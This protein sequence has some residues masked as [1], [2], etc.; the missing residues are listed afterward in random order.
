[1]RFFTK[2]LCAW[3]YCH[4]S[5]HFSLISASDSSETGWLSGHPLLDVWMASPTAVLIAVTIKSAYLSISCV[6]VSSGTSP[7]LSAASSVY[8]N[9]SQS[10]WSNSYLMGLVCMFLWGWASIEISMSRSLLPKSS[11][12]R[13]CMS[14]LVRLGNINAIS[15]MSVL[16]VL[17]SRCVCSSLFI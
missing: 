15:K 8:S 10:V 6:D 2:G 9:T 11:P 5:L 1:M 7:K 13:K 3:E 4:R 14:C 12:I 16:P 17:L